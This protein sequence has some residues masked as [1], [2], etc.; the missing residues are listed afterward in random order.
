MASY[1]DAI[2]QFNPYVQQLPVDVMAKV[3]MQKQAQYNQ[4]VQK[5]QQSIDNVAGLDIYSN[6]DKQHLQS[7]MDELGGKLR[8][9]AAGDF[10][11]QQLVNSVSGMTGSIIKD[12]VIQAA[13]YSTAHIKSQFEKIKELEKKGLTDKNN[14]DYFAD[15]LSKYANRTELTDEG[16]PIKFGEDYTPYTNISKAL[17][18][19]LVG[20][21]IDEK[22]IEQLFE[23]ENGLP[24]R[25]P[26]PVVDA[27]GKPVLDA[28]GKPKVD[29]KYKY[30][31]V[32]AVEKLGSNRAA[33]EAGI[34]NVFRRGDV[35]KQLQ[36]DGWANYR[37]TPI[38]SLI[39]PMIN[40]HEEYNALLDQQ[41]LE[42]SQLAIAPNISPEE[43]TQ[44]EEQIKNID[45]QLAASDK[46]MSSLFEFAKTN[47]EA[48]KQNYHETSVKNDLLKEFL[49][50]N[51][52]K[53]FE[54][55]PGKT[56]ENWDMD[57]AFKLMSENNQTRYQNASLKLQADDNKRGWSADKRD[58]ATFYR[59][60]V[61]NPVTGTWDKKPDPT[62]A[63]KLIKPSDLSVFSGSNPGELPVN[64]A[65]N[66]V[67]DDIL[68]LSV[69][70]RTQ[71]LELFTDMYR[72][73]YP[74]QD[75]TPNKINQIIQ[76]QTNLH[77]KNNPKDKLTTDQF[78]FRMVD[79]IQNKYT[80]NGLK[81]TPNAA[82]KYKMY[83][84]YADEL[85]ANVQLTTRLAEETWKEIG[86]ENKGA[87]TILKNVQ[88]TVNGKKVTITP[89]D[90]R[91]YYL[92]TG[93][94]A[95][96]AHP[97]NREYES[98]YVAGLPIVGS[99]SK[100]QQEAYDKL[101]AKFGDDSGFLGRDK[102]K[103]SAEFMKVLGGYGAK[104]NALLGGD[105]NAKF[106]ERYNE[107]LKKVV[108]VS[109]ITGGSL[110]WATGE[111]VKTSTGNVATYLS[112]ADVRSLGGATK[113]Q[114]L[115]ALDNATAISWV[116]KKPTTFR[117]DWTG[118][119]VITAK[120]DK[121]GE[122]KQYIID[123]VSKKDLQ[124]LADIQLGDYERRPVEM[125]I[126]S[127]QKTN[128]TNPSYPVTDP[129]AWKTAFLKGYKND[130]TVQQAGW[131]YRADAVR[132]AEGDGYRMVHYIK[133]TNGQ[134]TTIFGQ[135]LIKTDGGVQES[136]Q[137]ANI[138][139]LQSTLSN[140]LQNQKK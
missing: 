99:V 38:D 112:V 116:G 113:E 105:L 119:I 95:N 128:S 117:E 14:D 81:F 33:V 133:P 13:V 132:S 52:S 37:N 140:Y 2:S 100:K 89:E 1:T 12:P 126:R 16:N 134:F 40:K 53:T 68:A 35:K 79:G 104:G 118:K 65:R 74:K 101:A 5:I 3:G 54:V 20:A 29:Y 23:T 50:E 63:G 17:K 87:P 110:P 109:D 61:W 26:V 131:E 45:A 18:D 127:N 73:N 91:L 7:K 64:Y 122:A 48:F 36:I 139:T 138:Q 111:E 9:V 15:A 85:N 94:P 32:K 124:T 82:A 77:N 71:A 47:P 60:S 25:Y 31:N 39:D 78:L 55:N 22:T 84:Q 102:N 46:E 27:K 130:P 51:L 34:Q 90:Q 11:D 107:K 66:M 70:K 121:T 24:K 67:E 72:T 41:R 92:A 62:K 129:N 4:G 106:N 28:T 137:K 98:S 30:A 10:S 97:L 96:P 57:Y 108:G 21:G 75:F 83:T 59:D 56:Q 135:T 42:Y 86:E 49:K 44:L 115:G 136:F 93:D 123:D 76:A 58:W 103:W 6:I 69:G 120:A 43:K 8:T 88:T 125:A 19:E 114:V 80:E